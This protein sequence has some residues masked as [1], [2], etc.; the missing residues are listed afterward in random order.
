MI[1]RQ[2]GVRV[3][4]LRFDLAGLP[5]AATITSARL[6]LY[7]VSRSNTGGQTVEVYQML[8]PW[9]EAQANWNVAATGLPWGQPGGNRI[10][11]DR[12]ASPSA[13]RDVAAIN[14]WQEWDVTNLVRTWKANP[15]TNHGVAL[16]GSGAT[17]VE[18]SFAS[19]E[20]WWSYDLAPRL[21]VQYTMP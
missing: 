11:V 8:R 5:A 13:A 21:V 15:A 10:G 20:Y 2:G 14:V 1:V 6:G 19:S 16:H 9:S 18:Y 7:P 17:A 3:G 4:L 12:V